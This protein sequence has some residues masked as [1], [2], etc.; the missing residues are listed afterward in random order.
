MTAAEL[1]QPAALLVYADETMR[2]MS[3]QF[4]DNSLTSAPVIDRPSGTVV[5]VVTLFDLLKARLHDL[6]EERD[7]RRLIG[8]R[9]V[10]QP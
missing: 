2:H 1:A 6:E 9:R 3:Y 7:R 10:R 5:G 8:A 4:A